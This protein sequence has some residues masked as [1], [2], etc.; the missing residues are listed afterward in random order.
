[1]KSLSASAFLL[2]PGWM[3]REKAEKANNNNKKS[4]EERAGGLFLIRS[5]GRAKGKQSNGFL[6]ILHSLSYFSLSSFSLFFVFPLLSSLC[7]CLFSFCPSYASFLFQPPLA[8]SRKISLG[9]RRRSPLVRSIAG[10]VSLPRNLL[11][12]V[13]SSSLLNPFSIPF[14]RSRIG[15]FLASY[16]HPQGVEPRFGPFF[17]RSES[18]SL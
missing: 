11:L 2:P 10:A 8:A 6:C 1:M 14:S 5:G 17:F 4:K 13:F 3:S 18:S 7:R 9:R 12:L 16:I 15:G